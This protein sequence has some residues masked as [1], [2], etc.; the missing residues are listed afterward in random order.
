MNVVSVDQFGIHLGWISLSFF[1]LILIAG[2]LAGGGLAAW[3]ARKRGGNPEHVLDKLTWALILGVVVARVFYVFS[4]PPSAIAQGYT[5]RWYLTHPFNL[6]DGPLAIWHGGGLSQ[7]GAL[8]GGALGMWLYAL[9]RRLDIRKWADI[10]APGV[11]LGLAIASW[12]NVVNQQ[13]YGPPTNLPWGIQVVMGTVY[14]RRVPP[15]NDPLLYPPETQFHPTPAYLS[16]WALAGLAVIWLIQA[17]LQEHLK[18]GDI[19]LL[20]VLIYM[21]G[22]FLADFLRVDISPVVVGLSGTQVL[23]I[24][25][26]GAALAAFVRQRLKDD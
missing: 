3:Q 16:L 5:T 10:V 13:L 1:G 21:P 14:N 20:G 4:P 25:V 26:F 22:L 18:E 9:R 8:L 2:M 24:L 6:A 15:Y 23:A 11:L 19:A 12:A 7:A 17:R